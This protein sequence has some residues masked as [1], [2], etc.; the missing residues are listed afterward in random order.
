MTRLGRGR[1]IAV[2]VRLPFDLYREVA[3]RADFK[4]WS[5]SDYVNWCI[6]KEVSSKYTSVREQSQASP[7][8]AAMADGLIDRLEASGG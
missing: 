8:A 3:S 1:R 7:Y 2:T 5:M 6:A 4:G